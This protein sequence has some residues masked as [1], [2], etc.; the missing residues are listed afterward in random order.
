M[1]GGVVSKESCNNKFEH[2]FYEFD[3]SLTKGVR[4]AGGSFPGTKDCLDRLKDMGFGVIITCIVSPLAPGRFINHV[5]LNHENTE[6]SEE[7]LQG[8]HLNHFRLIHVPVA[9]GFG[10]TSEI[11]TYFREQLNLLRESVDERDK[12]VYIHCWGGKGRTNTMVIF[13]LMEL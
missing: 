3:P 12:N 10:P 7:E 11:L 8:E 5:P 1:G 9:D 2:S 13:A 4:I 6:W